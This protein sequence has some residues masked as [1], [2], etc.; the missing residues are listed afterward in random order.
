MVLKKGD[1]RVIA[2]L[3]PKDGIKYVET[4]K[5]GMA[6]EGLDSLYKVTMRIEDYINPTTDGNLSWKSISSCTS[7]SEEGLENWKQRMHEVSVGRCACI[8][9]SL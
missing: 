1:L 7:D 4:I 2:P 6:T 9:R 8:T 3:D 5:G